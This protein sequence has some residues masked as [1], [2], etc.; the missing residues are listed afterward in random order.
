MSHTEN[1]SVVWNYELRLGIDAL[2]Y[3]HWWHR[4]RDQCTLSMFADD[5]KLSNAGDKAG[6]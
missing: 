2:Q 3:L 1:I 4:E 6:R 5:T